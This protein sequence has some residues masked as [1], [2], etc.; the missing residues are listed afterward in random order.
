MKILSVQFGNPQNP[1]SHGGLSNLLHE[2][3]KR[4]APRHQITCYTGLIPGKSR[5]MDLD[6]VKY[7]QRGLGVNKYLNRSSYT[8]RNCFMPPEEFDLILVPWDRYAPVLLKSGTRCPVVLELCL[9]FFSIPTKLKPAE[10]ITRYFL[11]KRLENC[12]YL[13]SMSEGVQNIVIKHTENLRLKEVLPGGVSEE[14]FSYS[15]EPGEEKY[16]LFLGRLDI[17]HK[18]IDVLLESYKLAKVGVPLVIA[19]DG[20]DRKMVQQLIK[21]HG[22]KDYVRTVGWVQGKE[23]YDLI[24]D[25]IAVCIPSRVEG[26]GIV[27]TEA[28]AMGKPVIG[29]KVVGLEEAVADGKT[30][31][32]VQK[33]NIKAFATAMEMLV[34]DKQFRGI[35]GSYARERAQQYTWEK[36][37]EKREAF[38]EKVIADFRDKS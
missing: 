5:E 38:F 3:F 13:I 2:T 37:A 8:L 11:K 29:T 22:L 10:P 6:G 14:I 21:K 18:G 7:L 32:L 34:R 9:E 12:Q 17:S 36:I 25:C 33:D 20:I 35:L 16:L 27:A 15:V 26:W 31:I 28:A 30:G 23:K 4:M 1:Y 24:K 19:G